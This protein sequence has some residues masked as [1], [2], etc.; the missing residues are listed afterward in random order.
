MCEAK[1]VPVSKDHAMKVYRRVEAK[2]THLVPGT[3]CRSVS[4]SGLFMSGEEPPDAHFIGGWVWIQQWGRKIFCR[5]IDRCS[6]RSQSI[7]VTL[8]L[9]RASHYLCTKMDLKACFLLD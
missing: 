5:E 4:P 9:G 7:I 2:G 1:G 8:S 6:A 3:R